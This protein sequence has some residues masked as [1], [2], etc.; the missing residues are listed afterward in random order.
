MVG[1]HFLQVIL[2]GVW[3]KMNGSVL[4]GGGL[5]IFLIHSI[6]LFSI[7]GKEERTH[8]DVSENC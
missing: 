5:F 8:G 1:I 4:G 7:T 2:R 3:S 6:Y